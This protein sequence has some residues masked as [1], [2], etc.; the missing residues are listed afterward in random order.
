MKSVLPTSRLLR[1]SAVSIRAALV[2]LV[3]LLPIVIG[4][5]AKEEERWVAADTRDSLRHGK[6]AHL[7][8]AV[9]EWKTPYLAD[10]VEERLDSKWRRLGGAGRE[11][12][13]FLFEAALDQ[14]LLAVTGGPQLEILRDGRPVSPEPVAEGWVPEPGALVIREEVTRQSPFRFGLTSQ[15]EKKIEALLRA[16]RA[17]ITVN[18][19]GKAALDQ[20]PEMVLYLNDEEIARFEVRAATYNPYHATGIALPGSNW[21]TIEF[22]NDYW[23][24]PEDRNLYIG[25]VEFRQPATVIACVGTAGTK[26]PEPP[27]GLVARYHP[28]NRLA[29][30]YTAL[31]PAVGLEAGGRG[32]GYFRLGNDTRPAFPLA[33]PGSIEFPVEVDQP[34]VLRVGVGAV[35]ASQSDPPGAVELTVSTVNGHGES[36][37]LATETVTATDDAENSR[38]Y[39]F[40]YDLAGSGDTRIRVTAR[41]RASAGT[42]PAPDSQCLALLSEPTL[43]MKQVVDEA[44]AGI[45]L[46]SLDTLRADR[47]S[48]YGYARKTSPHLDS[49]AQKYIQFLHPIAQSNWTLPSHISMLSSLYVSTHGV[50]SKWYSVRRLHTLA[51]SLRDHGFRTKAVV[52]GGFLSAEYGL[53][54]G[55]ESY[56][57]CDKGGF[58]EVLPA[59]E[60][61]LG[62]YGRGPFFLFLHTYDTHGPYAPPAPFFD[63]FPLPAEGV[64]E[65]IRDGV[66]D[67]YLALRASPG[68][69]ADHP[70]S[71]TDLVQISNL[72]DS[73]IVYMDHLIGPF[74]EFLEAQP[75]WENLAVI[76]T[77]DHGEAMM[78]HGSLCH[79]ATFYEE[80]VRVPLLVRLPGMDQPRRIEQLVELVDLPA[81]ILDWAGAEIPQDMQGRSLMPL[82]E[83][84]EVPRKP[85][86][87]EGR[88]V[89]GYRDEQY[90]FIWGQN[91]PPEL[92]DLERDPWE[93][94]NLAARRPKRVDE[95]TN[96]VRTFREGNQGL[97]GRNVAEQIEPS[98]TLV[99]K[100]KALG[101]VSD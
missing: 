69:I 5:C 1:E 79:G 39:D 16:G 65:E 73:G 59:A 26:E 49:F 14:S 96:E 58:V 11:A 93:Q 44:A 90:K 57:S 3:P 43:Q 75:F 80:L 33:P 61:W 22:T 31:E 88:G 2:M 28:A 86:H 27:Q 72:Y 101:Y 55:F 18:A 100:L 92:Y 6:V 20:G 87:A 84:H 17:D 25:S 15:G 7:G 13:C 35:A 38:W 30:A 56:E 9:S 50:E 46:I 85:A 54:H 63:Y 48:C 77:S 34:A 76:I 91:R 36:H 98:D 29:R 37:R 24:P 78:E 60:Q 62:K 12:G 74:L 70:V 81:T 53:C 83:G 8:R 94:V 45:I 52:D 21:L 68:K 19:R 64:A 66:P 32:L 89:M 40:S 99:E 97:F 82:L 47:L 51:E 67:E 23:N 95:L 41:M 4:S 71:A 10:P 42:P